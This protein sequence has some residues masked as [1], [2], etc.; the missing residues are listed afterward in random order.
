MHIRFSNPIAGA[1][2]VALIAT[3]LNLGPA[4]AASKR[5][6]Q[7]QAAQST[8]VTTDFSARRRHYRGN[9]AALGAVVG[10]FGAIAALAAADRYRNDY[11]YYGSP[12]YGRPYYGPYSYG[13]PYYYAPRSRYGHHRHWR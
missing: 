9:R 12:Y 2:A 3:S 4:Q 5:S 10:V 13:G 1:L 8:A 6:A 11:Y 7:P